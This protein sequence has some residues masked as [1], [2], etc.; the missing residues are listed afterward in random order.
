M[1]PILYLQLCID[2]EDIFMK[3]ILFVFTFLTVVLQF[4]ATAQ[5]AGIPVSIT[6]FSDKTGPSN[7]RYNWDWW[8]SHLGDGFSDMLANE[9]AKS[10]KIELYERETINEI[11][12]DEHQL[13]NSQ[14]DHSLKIGKFKKAKFTFVGTITEFEYCS[15]SKGGEVNVGAVARL[16]GAP[17]PDV[18][19]GLNGAKAHLAMT[20]RIIDTT[21]GRVVKS[22]RS[23]ADVSDSKFDLGTKYGDF[24]SQENSPMGQA[25]QKAIEKAAIEALKVI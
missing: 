20:L 10:D 1:N 18:N 8:S 12:Y 19:I 21:T 14:K 13:V 5:A 9:L 3:S 23:E 2:Q 6:K 7:C 24:S 17:V 25:A 15:S 22:I 4:T 16:F 11:Y